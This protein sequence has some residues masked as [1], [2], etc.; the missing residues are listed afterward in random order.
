[1]MVAKLALVKGAVHVEQAVLPLETWPSGHFVHMGWEFAT[2]FGSIPPGQAVNKKNA[3][4]CT[5]SFRNFALDF[6]STCDFT[7]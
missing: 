7:R 3:Q 5:V 6:S 4:F 1:M 2:G